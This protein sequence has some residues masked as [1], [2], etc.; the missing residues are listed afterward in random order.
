MNDAINYS[1]LRKRRASY[2][3][4]H[5]EPVRVLIF[6]LCFMVAFM[7]YMLIFQGGFMGSENEEVIKAILVLIGLVVAYWWLY[8]NRLRKN[9]LLQRFA[10]DNGFRYEA[11]PA[12]LGD[13]SDHRF[14]SKS[15]LLAPRSGSRLT[16]DFILSGKHKNIPFDIRIVSIWT[17][18]SQGSN[19]KYFGL[20]TLKAGAFQALPPIIAVS[21]ET[22]FIRSILNIP[23]LSTQSD[24]QP[25]LIGWRANAR[26]DTYV[27]LVAE[28]MDETI[29]ERLSYFMSSLHELGAEAIE[30]N[31]DTLYILLSDGLDYSQPAFKDIFAMIEA[32]AH[33]VKQKDS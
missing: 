24:W 17:Q 27:E 6:S 12:V 26:Y 5:K 9:T 22:L 3:N 30:V 4:S 23:E 11:I 13:E 28:E 10:Q 32:A 21:K 31:N 7:L 2:A 33:Y 15:I 8:K 16:Y 25:Q 18:T 20:I 1:S 19:I 29:K 14:S